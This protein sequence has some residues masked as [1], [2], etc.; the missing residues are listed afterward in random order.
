MICKH[1]VFPLSYRSKPH[2]RKRKERKGVIF[3]DV[4]GKSTHKEEDLMNKEAGAHYYLPGLG[5]DGPVGL[6]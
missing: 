6:G 5:L 3:N 1:S 4:G 2:E